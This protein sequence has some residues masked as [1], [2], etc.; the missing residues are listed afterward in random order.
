[1]NNFSFGSE[2]E[3]T[4][5]VPMYVVVNCQWK[6]DVKESMHVLLFSFLFVS[7]IASLFVNRNHYFLGLPKSD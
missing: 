5:M 4:F 2:R 7:R 3:A 6:Y 1:M